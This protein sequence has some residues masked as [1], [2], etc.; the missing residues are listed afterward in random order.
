MGWKWDQSAGE[1]WYQGKLI[2]TGYAGNGRGKNNP[3]MQAAVGVGPIPRG[4]WRM[5]AVR[6]SA[7]TGPFSIVLE[8]EPGTAT[9]GRSAFRVHGDSV[10]NPGTASHGCIILPRAIR[11]RMWRS[12]EKLLEV[13]E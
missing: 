12:G 3:A 10:R 11:E 9:F 8:P 6:D 5:T 13:V 7:N 1:L 4:C 2:S